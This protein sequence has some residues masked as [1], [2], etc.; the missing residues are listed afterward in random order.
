M[1]VNMTM[2]LPDLGPVDERV[3]EAVEIG[4]RAIFDL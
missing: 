1:T 2:S 4:L 3:M